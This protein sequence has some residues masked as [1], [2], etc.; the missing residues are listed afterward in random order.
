MN[1][2]TRAWIAVGIII[3]VIAAFAVWQLTRT[4]NP[5]PVSAA[6]NLS[7]WTIPIQI[8]ASSTATINAD[9]SKLESYEGTT[10][11]PAA[12]IYL[13]IA[14]DYASLGNGQSAY[15]YYVKALSATSTQPVT[16]YDL[17]A[18]F[19]R[20]YATTTAT[21]AYALAVAADPTE[22]IFQL[23][24]LD[25]LAEVAPTAPATATA[26]AQARVTLGTSTPDFLIAEASWLGSIGSTTAAIADWQAVLPSVEPAQQAA[27]EARIAALK[28]QQ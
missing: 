10:T 5:F 3:V 4:P 19:A 16:Y 7:S 23:G 25:Y 20:L 17:G 2:S 27:V 21:R 12:D 28:Q 9:I 14:N 22:S 11:Y 13:G 15:H 8:D 26:F 24:Y 18:L 1:N 6:D